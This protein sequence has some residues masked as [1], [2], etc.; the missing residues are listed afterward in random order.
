MHFYPFCIC[1]FPCRILWASKDL[2]MLILEGPNL[3]TAEG[4]RVCH[5]LISVKQ[6]NVELFLRVRVQAVA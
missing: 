3:I 6:A 1:L 2:Q 4:F 5:I